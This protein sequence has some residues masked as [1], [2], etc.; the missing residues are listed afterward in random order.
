M[1]RR[2]RSVSIGWSPGRHRHSTAVVGGDS[3][4]ISGQG[5]T[6]VLHGS[7]VGLPLL[8]HKQPTRT[9]RPLLDEP[10]V[11]GDQRTPAGLGGASSR[12]PS[13]LGLCAGWPYTEDVSGLVCRLRHRRSV[14]AG[15]LVGPARCRTEVV[16]CGRSQ[17]LGG[18]W[19]KEV[20]PRRERYRTS[21]VP[22][23]CVPLSELLGIRRASVVRW[24]LALH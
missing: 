9:G 6:G 15:G 24:I 8:G 1:P 7:D 21:H 5:G 10:T 11:A 12:T 19:R 14:P 3:H 20:C 4:P 2:S 22:N 23:K 18:A 17:H 16:P 13:R